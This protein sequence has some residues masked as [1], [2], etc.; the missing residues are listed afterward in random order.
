VKENV[1]RLPKEGASD[2][3]CLTGNGRDRIFC[4]E[5]SMNCGDKGDS[6]SENKK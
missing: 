3:A 4:S 5:R 6:S 1:F 2:G